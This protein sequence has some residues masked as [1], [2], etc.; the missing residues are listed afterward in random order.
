V[1]YELT[2]RSEAAD[3]L[4]RLPFDLYE[5]FWDLLDALATTAVDLPASSLPEVEVH[6]YVRR[7]ERE[8]DAFLFPILIDYR[9]KTML[10]SLIESLRPA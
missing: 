7:T 5:D 6:V 8:I 2:L 4:A 1:G 9:T 3:F 10:V